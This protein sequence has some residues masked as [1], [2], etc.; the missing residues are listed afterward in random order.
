MPFHS[1]QQ[2]PVV[3]TILSQYATDQF[4]EMQKS[5]TYPGEVGIDRVFMRILTPEVGLAQLETGEIDLMSLPVAEIE[6]TSGIDGVTVVTVP[7]PSMDFL[8]VNLQRE[9]LQNVDVRKAMMH[10]IDRAG[11]VAQV[12]QGEGTVVNSPI[13]GP[14]WMGVPEGL[15]EYPYDPDG[16]KALLEGSGFDTSQEISIMHL[17]GHTGERCRCCH[18]AGAAEA[19]WLQ[20]QHPPGRCG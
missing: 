16:A 2:P 8:A 3:P 13:F 5:A 18:H 1:N 6:R 19:G 17:P 11:I 4:L 14:E 10:A 12:L 7:S 20:Y 9:F 15:D